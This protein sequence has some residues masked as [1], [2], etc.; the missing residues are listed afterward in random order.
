MHMYVMAQ[1]L[2]KLGDSQKKR[3]EVKSEKILNWKTI[4]FSSYV[5][6]SQTI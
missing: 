4:K 2:D 1:L 5:C 6:T 3:G